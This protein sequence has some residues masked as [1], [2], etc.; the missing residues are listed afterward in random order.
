MKMILFFLGQIILQLVYCKLVYSSFKHSSYFPYVAM[1]SGMLGQFLWSLIVR[2]VS[3]NTDITISGVIFDSV[4]FLVW[5]ILPL[6]LYGSYFNK[7]G[8]IGVA[9]V[10]IGMILVGLQKI[11]II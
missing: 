9:F 4:T 3:G 11:I 7:M 2:H 5:A 8:I 1:L 10:A 6:V